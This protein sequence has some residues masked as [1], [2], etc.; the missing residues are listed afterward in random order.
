RDSQGGKAPPRR[1]CRKAARF[2]ARPTSLPSEP[3]RACSC[4]FDPSADS[5]CCLIDL[6]RRPVEGFC[7]ICHTD[8]FD[9]P[10]QLD[11]GML[12]DAGTNGLTKVLDVG[13][14]SAAK[15]DQKIAVQLRYLRA[16]QLEPAA[17]RGIDK[18]PCLMP[19]RILECR[20]A[21]AALDRLRRL[22]RLGDFL[23][24]RCDAL[25]MAGRSLE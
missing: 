4:R 22:A 20:A 6:E 23:H 14:S 19:R 25:R 24:L 9:L 18:L 8:A 5:P 16:A 2:P 3:R 12:F 15:I 10:F 17:S 7:L 21:G 1:L 13:G 11:A